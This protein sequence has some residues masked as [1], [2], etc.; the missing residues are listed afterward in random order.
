MTTERLSLDS[1]L[2]GEFE[3]LLHP[4]ETRR[5]VARQVPQLIAEQL[6]RP[7]APEQRAD[8]VA[9]FV[10]EL[11][12]ALQT[13]RGHRWDLGWD[14]LVAGFAVAIELLAGELPV[15]IRGSLEG[16][17]AHQ[18]WERWRNPYSRYTLLLDADVRICRVFVAPSRRM[19]GEPVERVISWH[20]EGPPFQGRS[21]TLLLALMADDLLPEAIGPLAA[22]G[23]LEVDGCTVRPVLGLVEKAKAWR[24]SFPD[25]MLVTGPPGVLEREAWQALAERKAYGPINSA[26]TARW[27][28][29]G[30]IA[31]LAA[32]L[33]DS[34]PIITSWDGALLDAQGI[35]EAQIEHVSRENLE[36]PFGDPLLDTAWAASQH[37]S[38][39]G[40]RRGVLIEGQPGAGKSILSRVLEHR[41]R[42]GVRGAL[43]FGVRRSARELAEDLRHA[44]TRTWT[45]L[46]SHR[47]PGRRKLFEELERT[48]R[49][50]PIVD[51]L[52]E[53]SGAQLR[54]VTALLRTSPGWWM[55]TSRPVASIIVA[56]PPTWTLQIKEPSSEE[57]RKLLA[58]AGRADLAEFLYGN[59]LNHSRLPESLVALTRTPLHLA[60]LAKVTRE[61]ERL[62]QLAAHELYRRVFQGL[63]DQAC[64]DQRLTEREARQLRELQ[65]NAIGELALSWLRAPSGYLDRAMVDLILEEAGFRASERPDI[66][67]AL[68]F[69]HLLAPAGDAWDFAHRTLAEWAASG[70]LH[71]EVTRRQREHSRASG[72]SEDRGQLARIELEILAPFL[73]RRLLVDSSPWAQ[74]LRFYAPYISEPLAVLDRLA[75]PVSQSSWWRPN[76]R[77]YPER[78]AQEPAPTRPATAS[79]VLHTW[80]FIFELLAQAA[81]KRP[82]DARTAWGIAV[83]R[84]LLFEHSDERFIRDE[85]EYPQLGVFAE[86]VASHLPISLS[87]LCSIAGRTEAQIERLNA[88]PTLLLPAIPPTRAPALEHLLRGASQKAQLSVLKWYA[89]HGMEV[90]G[91]VIDRLIQTLPTE[92]I[93]AE[94][95][96]HTEWVKHRHEG[97]Q[98]PLPKM[99][100][101]R[102]LC[103]LE[104]L[105]WESSLRTRRGL[106]WP[107]VRAKLL[108]WPQH[109]EKSILN[110]FAV[111]SEAQDPSASDVEN[112]R[113]REVL[114]ACLAEASTAAEQLV[115]ELKR[116]QAEPGGPEAVGHVW[117]WLDDSDDRHLRHLLG[118]LAAKAGWELPRG[119]ARGAAAEDLENGLRRLYRLKQRPEA[120]LRA[121]DETR[122]EPVVGGLWLLLPPNQPEH[123]ALLEA[124]KAVDRPPPQIPASWWLSHHGKDSWRLERTAWTQTHLAELRALS[125]MGQGELR[126]AAI[127]L[128]AQREKRDE[129]LALLQSLPS[130][131]EELAALIRD[132]LEGRWR[133]EDSVPTELLP[134]AVLAHLPLEQRAERDV[135]GWRAELIARLA[136]DS[137]D[138]G[139]LARLAMRKEVRE[140]LPLLADRLEKS[141]WKDR[142]LIAAIAC[143]CTETDT[144]WARVALRNALLHGWPGERADRPGL[145][146]DEDEF[147]SASVAL[148][149]FFTLD[150]L[151]MLVRGAVSAL[152]YPALAEA[153]RRLGPAAR[154]RLLAW[155]REVAEEVAE[156]ERHTQARE[157]GSLL[158][159]RR[160]EPPLESARARKDLLAETLVASFDPVQGKLADLVDLAFQVA[161]G[162]V[163]RVYGIPGPLGSD[164]DEPG[165]LD[166]Y[167]D[168]ENE[169]LVKALA[170]QVEACLL[171]DPD[172]WTELRRLFQ[173][174]SETLRQRVFELCADRASPHQVAELALEALEGHVRAN[175]TRWAGNTAGYMLSGGPGAGTSY[176]DSPNTLGRLKDA[177]RK[178][179][180]PAHRRVIEAL[181]GHELPMFRALAAQWA[182][183]LG[184]ESWIESIRPLLGDLVA[185]V[186]HWAVD[187]FLLLAP[188]RLDEALHKADRSAWTSLH[189]TYVLQRLR[190]PEQ[191]SKRYPWMESGEHLPVD[192]LKYVSP[193]TVELLL[194]ESAGRCTPVPEDARP[195]PTP[196]DGFPS[197]VEE[198]CTSL[199]SGTQPSPGSVVM[200]A[201]WSQHSVAR[202]RAVARRLRATRGLLTSQE[203]LP[204]LSSE[205]LEQISAAECLVRMADE[206][207]REEAFAFW[208][209]ALGKS[210]RRARFNGLSLYSEALSDRL[211]WALRGAT[212]AFAPLLGLVAHHIGYD[213]A[214]GVDTPEGER[215][216]KQ[217]LRVIRRW[218]EDGVVALLDLIEARE[219][220][221]H[222]DFMEVVKATARRSDSF[223]EVLR[224]RAAESGG[225]A[226]QAYTELREE[227]ERSDLDGLAARL[228][229]EVF[230]K[231][232][233]IVPSVAQ[234]G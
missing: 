103:E 164:F 232:W 146:R 218:N 139:D 122:L 5:R 135:P 91:S 220:D 87:E 155:H 60:L 7:V 65:V 57:G 196:F 69:G 206:T 56:L 194:A 82:E 114:A 173:H 217:T 100:H 201:Q 168:Q 106:P 230:P 211:M 43:G 48:G 165:D 160:E 49:L 208:Q 215:V 188:E 102:L 86:A 72:Q 202:V 154:E 15:S 18:L 216:V 189:D 138:V 6:I 108:L 123:E 21:H 105:V 163:H 64:Q 156:L 204:L 51:G 80:S 182:G 38:E 41:F 16:T 150:D 234:S 143:L 130:A 186:V 104:A 98:V 178:R 152:H 213:H 2:H 149:S 39:Q 192:P 9:R 85:R 169:A 59:V 33:N 50:V 171:R 172:S 3:N 128:L 22:T 110:W 117:S 107:L 30:S 111:R 54:D 145:R 151:D 170:S 137:H 113:R 37:G 231:G 187:A 181:V 83:R 1:V 19:L 166:W 125:A 162:D 34:A 199:W 68:E 219:V 17:P 73:E 180:T 174:P 55:A 233:P 119:G 118:E 131:D 75:G 200:L 40:G 27:L 177:V 203:L 45:A 191:T 93:E 20:H 159:P 124:I 142:R 212:P 190:P 129:T 185:G 109:L 136:R 227:L 44:P 28:A 184:N 66:V 205:P 207:H 134:P 198:L 89:K 88:E 225:P 12:P 121:L 52:D 36:A 179:L 77:R 61:G 147:S 78:S 167:S 23:E 47:E 158:S 112:Q 176:V 197:P 157:E 228:S 141:E 35:A 81:W 46:L 222:Y 153:I 14:E 221:D 175:R 95:E 90:D 62:E 63:L 214:E 193:T 210:E 4:A 79:E 26:V 67:R 70:A 32:K 97:P 13:E 58:G 74:L 92:V 126:F 183:Q 29:G 120:I 148:A 25:G 132:H 209:A 42:S 226:Q 76:E 11:W 84:W 195:V 53:L 10:Q 161:G 229:A 101:S 127:R 99:A 24:Q 94:A 71:R 115:N 8:W 223:R 133:W 116:L 224:K 96:A 31:E 140:A 144:R